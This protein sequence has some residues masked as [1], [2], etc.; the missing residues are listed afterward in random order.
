M[1]QNKKVII[2][3]LS[4]V[5]AMTVIACSCSSL[6]SLLPTGSSGTEPMPGLAGKW[7]NPN[8]E[9]VIDIAWQNNQYVVLSATWKTTTYTISS[10]SWSGSSLTWTYDDTDLGV[11]VTYTTTSLSGDVLYV[12]WSYSDGTSGD[13]SFN[14]VK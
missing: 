11:T 14:R 10:Q 7:Q 12:N 9:D 4:F 13:S 1:K 2:T 5:L 6:S 8:T 3:I